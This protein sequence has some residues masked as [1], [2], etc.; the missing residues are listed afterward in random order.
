MHTN[1]NGRRTFGVV[2]T[3]FLLLSCAGLLSAQ[4]RS[5]SNR[6]QSFD[7]R[8]ARVLHSA[9]NRT[10]MDAVAALRDELNGSLHATYDE[11]SGVTRGLMNPVGKLT[12]PTP[13]HPLDIALDFLHSN[14]GLLGLEPGDL[15]EIEICDVVTSK[16][17]GTTHVYLCQEHRGLR[18]YNAQLQFH[19]SGDGAILGVNNGLVPGL[20]SNGKAAAAA[21]GDLDACM[22]VANHLGLRP[23]GGRA[24]RVSDLST[25]PIDA[26]LMWLPEGRDLT[27]VWRFQVHTPDGQHVYDMTVS[28][29]DGPDP[30]DANRV[31]T[32]F[33]WVSS[34]LYQVYE[35][36]AESPN[37]VSPVPPEDGRTLATS[38]EDAFASPLGWHDTGSASYT[39]MRGNNVHAYDDLDANDQPPAVEPDCGPGKPV[40]GNERGVQ[41]GERRRCGERLATVDR[42]ARRRRGSLRQRSSCREHALGRRDGPSLGRAPTLRAPLLPHRRRALFSRLRLYGGAHDSR[43]HVPGARLRASRHHGSVRLDDE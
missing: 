17:S 35:R 36:P 38:P 33:D 24:L 23:P 10:Q 3:A 34:G 26:K 14:L 2:G 22:A 28:A 40:A 25:E 21:I 42:D 30:S 27:L 43:D 15:D 32:R 19:V 5:Q 13:G 39:T 11:A 9:P 16:A 20:R 29:E 8:A 31:M 7:R 6:T 41:L 12:D 37:H 18:I 1:T 4:G